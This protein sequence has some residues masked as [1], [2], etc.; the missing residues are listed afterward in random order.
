MSSIREYV[1]EKSTTEY[2]VQHNTCIHACLVARWAKWFNINL[3][4]VA[5]GMYKWVKM[6]RGSHVFFLPDREKHLIHIETVKSRF[7]D[8]K[9][10]I[11]KCSVGKGLSCK[12]FKKAHTYVTEILE[13][14]NPAEETVQETRV[15]TTP[16]ILY[17]KNINTTT[18]F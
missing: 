18:L 3:R 17:F 12:Y 16:V 14:R 7:H 1:L 13:K 9:S 2:K 10:A 15:P 6:Y 11:F 5:N 4:P 8:T